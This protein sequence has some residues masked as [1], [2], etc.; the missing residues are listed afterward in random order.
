MTWL[1]KMGV[2]PTKPL[3]DTATEFALKFDKIFSMLWTI[4]YRYLTTVWTNK[5]LGLEGTTR[6]SLIHSSHTILPSSKIRRFAF[7]T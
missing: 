4:F 5:L 1:T 6:I 3:C 7:E 2:T